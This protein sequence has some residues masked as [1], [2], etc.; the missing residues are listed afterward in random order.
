MKSDNVGALT[1]M[2][3]MRPATPQM[4]IIGR[5]IALCLAELA[6]PPRVT[7]T[8]GISHIVADMLSKLHQPGC[9]DNINHPSLEGARMLYPDSR[10]KDWYVSLGNYM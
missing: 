9:I 8:P 3:K 10:N 2:L 4:A 6:F 5:E 7:H 1:L